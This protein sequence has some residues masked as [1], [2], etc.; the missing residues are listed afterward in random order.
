MRVQFDLRPETLLEKERKRTSFNATRIMAF[1]F[2]AV[3]VLTTSGYIGL[4]TKKM[5]ELQSSI[6]EVTNEVGNKESERMAL[7]AEISRLREQEKTYAS[8]LQI[9]QDDLPTLEVLNAFEEYMTYGMGLETLRFTG[10]AQGGGTN[11]VLEATSA[12]EEQIAELSEKLK[13]CG[14]FSNVEMPTSKRDER[15]GRISFTLNLVALPIGQIKSSEN[16]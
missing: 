15:T 8:T 5:F 12:T 2:L 14:V 1:L 7:F 11:A 4:M 3:F 10:P 13:N 6:D 9:M 16:R